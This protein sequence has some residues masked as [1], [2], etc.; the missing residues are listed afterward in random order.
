ALLTAAYA[1]RLWL[2]AFRGHGPDAPGHGRQPLSMTAVLWVLAVPSLAF[3][4]L[5]FRLLPDWF[6]GAD[7]TPAL[8]TSVLGTGIALTGGIVTY[9]AWHHTTAR[10]AR[11]P[12]GA[13]AAHPDRPDA[14]DDRPRGDAARVEAEAITSHTP[15]YGGIAAAPDPADPGRLLLGP[16]HRHAAA[17]FHLDAVYSA[18][19]VRPVRGAASLVRFLDREVVDTYVRG[20]AA[21]PRWLGTA[22]RRA[23]TGNVQTYVSALLAGT[24]V[25][26]VAAVLVATGA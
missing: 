8:T 21:L 6:D 16:L 25:L 5:A 10:A 15:A 26:A 11:F 18:L 1:T 22:V 7:L 3:G 19:F 20:A 24:V 13:V 17:G 14:T 9:A 4:G 23:Q 2:L 12:L